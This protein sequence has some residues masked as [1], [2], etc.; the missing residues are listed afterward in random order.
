MSSESILASVTYVVYGFFKLSTF[1]RCIR[2]GDI[3][4]TSTEGPLEHRNRS[5]PK[6]SR[7]YPKQPSMGIFNRWNAS[8]RVEAQRGIL[9]KR[10]A[11]LGFGEQNMFRP[12]GIRGSPGATKSWL[13]VTCA[14]AHISI[15]LALL[16]SGRTTS[17]LHICLRGGSR[18]TN[19]GLAA[20]MSGNPPQ[21]P[22]GRF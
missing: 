4:G 17:E 5:P 9:P 12:G 14:F 7:R 22:R 19:H 1:S 21:T 11:D 16:G 15:L 8:V 18:W 13:V 6:G 10:T 20:G 3:P 2:C